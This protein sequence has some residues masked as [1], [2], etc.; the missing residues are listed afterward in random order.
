MSFSLDRPS[1]PPCTP[2]VPKVR[3]TLTCTPRGCA[4]HEGEDGSPHKVSTCDEV[5]TNDV[6]S[7]TDGPVTCTISDSLN[8]DVVR[9]VET[10]CAFGGSHQG[11]QI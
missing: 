6:V 3:G 5:S 9:Q 1:A 2:L 10:R 8:F 4:A 11:V 7:V